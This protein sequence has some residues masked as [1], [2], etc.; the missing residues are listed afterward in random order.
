MNH[1]TIRFSTLHLYRVQCDCAA[2]VDPC[3]LITATL[4][5][6]EIFSHG[7]SL[8]SAKLPH[9]DA[10]YQRPMLQQWKTKMTQEKER[11]ENN[12]EAAAATVI[13]IGF[14]A[15]RNAAEHSF[16][17]RTISPGHTLLR[18][19]GARVLAH[20]HASIHI[21]YMFASPRSKGPIYTRDQTSGERTVDCRI[22][23]RIFIYIFRQS[24]CCIATATVSRVV[25]FFSFSSSVV[26][27]LLWF[28]RSFVAGSSERTGR[29]Q[30]TL[31]SCNKIKAT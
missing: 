17:Q 24:H 12:V 8:A 11:R 30:D 1:L 31:E 7:M 10:S 26:S 13:H 3:T 4:F 20:E 6:V 29:A 28:V 19:R 18:I 21:Y 2:A 14:T 15:Y 22:R 16:R 9:I 5:S 25:H 23:V 27:I